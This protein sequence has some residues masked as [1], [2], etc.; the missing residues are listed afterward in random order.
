MSTIKVNAF[1][2]T[3]GVG[4]Y[5]A[6]VWNVWEQVGTQS[7]LASGNVSSVTDNGTGS[8]T[9]NYSNSLSSSNYS[10]GCGAGQSASDPYRYLGVWVT[11]STSA[12][13]TQTLHTTTSSYDCEY[14]AITITI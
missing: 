7:I 8:S 5:P 13:R 6:R 2:N 11:M 9:T 14:N 10:I 3:S 1:Q 4:L 12:V